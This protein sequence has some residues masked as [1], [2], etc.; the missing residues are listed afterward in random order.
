MGQLIYFFFDSYKLTKSIGVIIKGGNPPSLVFEAIID[1]KKGNKNFGH[2]IIN[3]FFNI[4]SFA[5]LMVKI[6]E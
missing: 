6:P 3:I 1:L 2:S 5:F 4:S